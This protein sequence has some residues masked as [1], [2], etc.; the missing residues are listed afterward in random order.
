MTYETIESTINL[1][2]EK[3]GIAI[4]AASQLV[5]TVQKYSIINYAIWIIVCALCGISILAIGIKWRSHIL[6][7]ME[8]DKYEYWSD[9]DAFIVYSVFGGV[10]FFGFIAGITVMASNIIAWNIMPTIQFLKYV[11]SFIGG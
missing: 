9:H 7:L 11:A 1:L 5:P 4:N 8:K 2:C 3:F 10:A 6:K